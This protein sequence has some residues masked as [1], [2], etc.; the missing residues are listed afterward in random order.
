MEGQIEV[1]RRFKL[2]LTEEELRELMSWYEMS[3]D[4]RGPG[5]SDFSD[6]LHIQ[7][8]ALRDGVPLNVEGPPEQRQMDEF[9]NRESS[10]SQFDRLRQTAQQQGPVGSEWIERS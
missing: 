3:K 5:G 8:A 10:P 9:L 4:E 7:L 2:V 1:S 6:K